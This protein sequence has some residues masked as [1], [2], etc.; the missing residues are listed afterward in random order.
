MA[1]NTIFHF[2]GFVQFWQSGWRPCLVYWS[3]QCR[4]RYWPL[5]SRRFIHWKKDFTDGKSLEFTPL[6][7]YKSF[8]LK[9]V[10][11]IFISANDIVWQFDNIFSNNCYILNELNL[12][13]VFFYVYWM[14]FFNCV[15]KNCCC[16]K[17]DGMSLQNWTPSNSRP[18]LHTHISSCE[19]AGEKSHWN[20]RSWR[21]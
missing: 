3:M 6:Q 19:M 9:Q 17:S 5:V 14:F 10:C 1:T 11:S 8:K 12:V 4:H 15:G 20:Q 2:L 21:W 18:R 16:C 7:L 13:Q